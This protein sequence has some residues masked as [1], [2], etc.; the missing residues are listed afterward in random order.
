MQ[1]Q[2]PGETFPAALS[3]A[4]ALTLAI[5]VLSMVTGM[6]VVTDYENWHDGTFMDVAEILGGKLLTTVFVFGA[7]VSV[8]GL[9]CTLLCSSSRII[10]G[11][12]MVGTLPKV[13]E[14]PPPLPRPPSSSAPGA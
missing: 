14:P 11:M 2:N 1:V 13:R 9:L 6:S 5:D 8:I 3:F 12:A 4:M 10:Y 7:A